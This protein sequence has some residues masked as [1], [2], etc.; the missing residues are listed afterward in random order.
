MA[1]QDGDSDL[2][3]KL[4]AELNSQVGEKDAEADT[5]I[6]KHVRFLLDGTKPPATEGSYPFFFFFFLS[7]KILTI[8]IHY[9]TQIEKLAAYNYSSF[10]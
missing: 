7:M 10:W 8:G 4:D 1:A 2:F 3:G 6:Q 9:V 5:R